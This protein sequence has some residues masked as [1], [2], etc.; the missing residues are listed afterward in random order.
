MLIGNLEVHKKLS[1]LPRSFAVY[2]SI[3]T[4]LKCVLHINNHFY[5]HKLKVD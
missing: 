3:E 4:G 2:F 5:Y 1:Y